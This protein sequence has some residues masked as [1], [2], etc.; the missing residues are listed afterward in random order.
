MFL[1]GHAHA[2]L[3]RLLVAAVVVVVVVTRAPRGG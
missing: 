3:S 1:S 2:S